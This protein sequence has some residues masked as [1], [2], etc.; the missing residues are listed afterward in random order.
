MEKLVLDD[1]SVAFSK[2]Q[3][4]FLLTWGERKAEQTVCEFLNTISFLVGKDIEEHL[5]STDSQY[6]T[7]RIPLTS[8]GES[9]T[10]DLHQ[11]IRL[12]NAYSQQMFLLKLEDLLMRKGI[13][14]AS[15]L[16]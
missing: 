15:S 2:R 8:R 16:F 13:K 1:I 3:G 6:D 9:I 12:R 10:L 7:V 14:P 4:R 5:L 11:F